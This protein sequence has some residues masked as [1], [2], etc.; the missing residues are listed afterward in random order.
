MPRSRAGGGRIVL[1]PMKIFSLR[2]MARRTS[3][4]LTKGEI[5]TTGFGGTSGVTGGAGRTGACTLAVLEAGEEESAA[6]FAFRLPGESNR[7][8][9]IS[10]A[11]AEGLGN[12]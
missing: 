10:A 1:G 8:P 2:V 12:S 5:S 7:R 6:G 11:T 3:F 4:S 9:A